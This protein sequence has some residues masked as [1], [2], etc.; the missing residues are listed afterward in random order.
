MDMDTS[1]DIHAKSVDMDMDMDREF[2][3]HGNPDKM[4]LARA[5]HFCKLVLSTYQARINLSNKCSEPHGSAI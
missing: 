4:P 2:H 1:M 3:I 5:L